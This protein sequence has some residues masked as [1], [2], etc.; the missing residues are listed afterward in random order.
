MKKIIILCSILIAITGY[1]ASEQKFNYI[2][3]KQA[4][5]LLNQSE[6][7]R[8]ENKTA[9]AERVEK[10]VNRIF[11]KLFSE[12]KII[13]ATFIKNDSSDPNE[14]ILDKSEYM[15]IGDEYSGIVVFK[16]YHGSAIARP[17]AKT[18]SVIAEKFQDYN[19]FVAK[20]KMVNIFEGSF[21]APYTVYFKMN[22]IQI[23]CKIISI[24]E[25]KN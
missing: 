13:E 21:G 16:I 2:L 22:L 15:S 24:N 4:I 8:T 20:I 12:N 5:D 6:N 7:F 3:F 9:K 18:D 1:A 19:K 17:S 11:D 14:F 10:E 23:D 25:I